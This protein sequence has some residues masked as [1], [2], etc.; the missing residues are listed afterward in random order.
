MLNYK[1]APFEIKVRSFEDA[2]AEYLSGW[3]TKIIS[4]IKE[5]MPSWGESHLHLKFDDVHNPLKHYVHPTEWH[6]QRILDFTKNLTSSDKVLVHCIAGISRSTSAAIAI[7]IQHGMS[8]EDAYN[9]ISAQRRHLA[10]NRLVVSYT[11]EHFGLNG[12]YYRFVEERIQF[13]HIIGWIEKDELGVP[14]IGQ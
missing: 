7:L 5:D 14:L 10:P 13:K 4:L 2:K 1:I 6:F 3:P 9:H 11:D 12:D 8:Y